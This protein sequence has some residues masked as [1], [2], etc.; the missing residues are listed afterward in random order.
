MID[1]VVASVDEALAD[2]PHGAT[3]LVAGWGGVGIPMR[4]IAGVL[5]R[6][7]R[8]LVL[9]TNNCGMG[10]E[11]DVGVLFRHGMV[12]K[13]CCSFPT[14]PGAQD[15][16]DAYSRGEVTVELIP[17]G[18][19]TERIRAAGAGIGGFYTRTGVGTI[20]A[21]GR[22]V[23]DIDGVPHLFERPLGGDF[24]LIHAFQGD[25]HG[26]LRYKYAG[27]AFNPVMARA[28]KVTIAEVEEL[29][30]AGSIDPNDVHTPGIYV[31][32]VVEVGR[33]R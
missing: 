16:R 30:P 13:A 10:M 2:V 29:V 22:E 1:K 14:H 24:A 9:V 18:T 4:L 21:E 17:Q 6:G 28:A 26:N 23:R 11:G 12:R 3:L 15:F 32:R 25:K 19:L 27:R 31:D 33:E 5:K 20:V 8:D 7:V